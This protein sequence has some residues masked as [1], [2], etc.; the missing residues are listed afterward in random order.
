MILRH[1]R[2]TFTHN[3][4]NST[5]DDEKPSIVC[6]SFFYFSAIFHELPLSVCKFSSFFIQFNKKLNNGKT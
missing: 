2:M 6:Y 3:E 4:K 1:L 5:G